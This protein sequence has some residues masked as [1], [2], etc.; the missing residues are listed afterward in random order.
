MKKTS[1]LSVALF[2]VMV[3]MPISATLEKE[4][5]ELQ[6]KAG[7]AQIVEISNTDSNQHDITPI[8]RL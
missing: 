2:L 8:L 5:N 7:E 6:T 4:T 3:M 1:I